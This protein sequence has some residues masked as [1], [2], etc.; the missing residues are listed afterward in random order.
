[1]E[2]NSLFETGTSFLRVDQALNRILKP[3]FTTQLYAYYKT[4][5]L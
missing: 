5:S 3:F 1:M 4:S 2:R